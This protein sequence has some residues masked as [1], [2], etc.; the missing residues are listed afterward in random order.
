MKHFWLI[1]AL[2]FIGCS[3]NQSTVTPSDLERRW[4]TEFELQLAYLQDSHSASEYALAKGIDLAQIRKR[5]D[6]GLIS[7]RSHADAAYLLDHLGD[8]VH[9]REVNGNYEIAGLFW[10]SYFEDSDVKDSHLMI[11]EILRQCKDTEGKSRDNDGQESHALAQLSSGTR[12]IQS[13]TITGKIQVEGK[14]TVNTVSIEKSER[15]LRIE[16]SGLKPAALR[17]EGWW[18]PY[19]TVR[20]GCELRLP[21]LQD[22]VPVSAKLTVRVRTRTSFW[23][24]INLMV[25]NQTRWTF[26]DSREYQDE[27][28]KT[29]LVLAQ[30]E[31]HSDKWLGPPLVRIETRATATRW[32]ALD[33]AVVEIELN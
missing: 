1:T 21:L 26:S 11:H 10:Q 8:R 22:E 14:C 13:K 28:V 16:L 33:P 20:R 27:D 25:Q 29:E 12:V 2:L 23:G 9:A 31:T 24:E 30:K 4:M 19:H 6:Q 17:K 15:I 32:G 5:L 3:E 7:V 18:R